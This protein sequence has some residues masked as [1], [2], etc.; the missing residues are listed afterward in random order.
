MNASF[1]LSL[2]I[3]QASRT[4]Q[5]LENVAV[6]DGGRRCFLY[7]GAA[8]VAY[9]IWCRRDMGPIDRLVLYCAMVIVKL[10][11]RLSTLVVEM[12]IAEHIQIP[13]N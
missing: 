9:S 6:I 8:I 10:P 7:V 3:G 5:I 11:F 13:R 4:S 12:G 2:E 1:I